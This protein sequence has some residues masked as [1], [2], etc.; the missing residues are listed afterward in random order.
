MQVGEWLE[1]IGLGQY[2]Q[3]FSEQ[4]VDDMSLIARL[5]ASD[6]DRLGVLIGHRHKLLAAA[7]DSGSAAAIAPPLAQRRQLT[8]VMCDLVD[9]TGLSS[10]LDPEDLHDVM[11]AYDHCV[12]HAMQ[13]HG[14]VVVER[15]GDSVLACFGYPR[16][17][18][19]DAV[20]ATHAAL[21]VVDAVGRLRV[22]PTVL[23]QA[24]AGVATG[25]VVVGHPGNAPVIGDAPNLAARLQALAE[26]GTIAVCGRTRMLSARRFKYVD[27]GPAVLKGYAE[28]V[29]AW[30]VVQPNE[31]PSRFEASHEAG[32]PPLVGREE[33]LDTLI[34]R[35]LQVQAGQGRVIALTG[36]P[37]IGKS[38]L[39]SAFAQ[40]LDETLVTRLRY[41]CAERL[42]N[43]ALAP[44]M[45]QIERVAGFERA[46][47]VDAKRA[48]LDALL[49][50]ATVEQVDLVASLFGLPAQSTLL[51]QLT[52][53]QRK[54]RTFD[55]LHRYVEALAARQPVLVIFEDVH[56]IDPT[57]LEFLN[58]LVERA[59]AHPVLLLIT[60]RR[61]FVPPWASHAH[62]TTLAI[63]RLNRR[64]GAELIRRVAAG[65]ALPEEI[66]DDILS[67][68]DGVPLFVE[69]LT[70]NV[71]EAGRL[72]ELTD[73][74]VGS[75]PARELPTTL[76]ASLEA[77]LDRLGTAKEIA[78]VGAVAGRDFSYELLR[79]VA[80][81]STGALDAALL[82]L[83]RAELL[84]QHGTGANAVY[85]FKHALLRDAAIATLLKRRR[86]ELHAAVA[87]TMERYFPEVVEAHPETV[88]DHL[89]EAGLVERAIPHWL[90]AGR[91]AAERSANL[92]AIAHLQR[93]VEVVRQ[94]APNDA[95]RRTELDLLMA[96]APCLIATQ[97]PAS[98]AALDTFMNAQSLC[99]QLNAPEYAKT[100]FW[101]VTAS[102]VRGE[103]EP[104]LQGTRAVRRDAQARG[105]LAAL[106]NASRGEAMIDMFMGRIRQAIVQMQHA[107]DLYTQASESVQLATRDNGQ[108]AA[109]AASAQL[110]WLV[111]LRGD[112]PGA[113]RSADAALQRAEL[114][115]HP[116]THAYVSYYASILHAL[117]RNHGLARDC[118]NRCWALSQEHGF[119]QWLG[120][121]Q[122]VAGICSCA[123]G[124][125][126]SDE[127]MRVLSEYRA[128]GYQLGV[129]VLYVLHCRALLDDGKIE[130]AIEAIDS[131]LQI[132]AQT[133]EHFV[134]AEL[135]RLRARAVL[136][137]SLPDSRVQASRWLDQALMT[138]R[139]QGSTWLELLAASDLAAMLVASGGR[140]RV[141]KLLEPL[142]ASLRA[143]VVTEE[144]A[145]ARTLLQRAKAGR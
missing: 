61:E 43:S 133:G 100:T 129:T 22:R 62:V 90:R 39:A 32:P 17:H 95:T 3:S 106:I 48:K 72:E 51:A 138:A 125:G 139:E 76:R 50:G 144:F 36:E 13:A 112:C 83:V 81:W 49:A 7:L 113:I 91:A 59:V 44:A 60:A 85:S 11:T 126:S 135:C 15:R 35:W 94:Q 116:H 46:D 78:Q 71:L 70:K 5:T 31:A 2:R 12:V 18:E 28:P 80:D 97:G 47:T 108:D 26:P 79:T 107:L 58:E 16:A 54:S 23:L 143:N 74:F 68:T 141:V 24:R 77:R 82:Q 131:A 98:R 21:A 27:V 128:S 14:G 96:L 29:P 103:L 8:V 38:H 45:V 1:L 75:L 65:K 123:H 124:T 130:P 64:E 86:A 9:S 66:T 99:E 41:D 37:G 122:A 84:Q 92:E 40:G 56:W 115:Q 110:A 104:A 121:S 137:S 117:C 87:D 34:R 73:R 134:D 6:L 109:A 33:E 101:I 102:V 119:R 69:E 19:D 55:V 118:A 93:G 20:Q 142:L 10:R 145:Y 57:T 136:Q 114:T 4:A 89:F 25:T 105:D 42:S 140:L 63:G 120:L 127:V 67:R 111:W 88:A 132:A 30:R 52:P 53:Q